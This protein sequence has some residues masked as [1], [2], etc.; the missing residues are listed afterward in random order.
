MPKFNLHPRQRHHLFQ[1]SGDWSMLPFTL[2]IPSQLNGH[3]VLAL[4]VGL[5]GGDSVPAAAL[6]VLLHPHPA[7]ASEQAVSQIDAH[8]LLQLL[9]PGSGLHCHV[10]IATPFLKR[11]LPSPSP[12]CSRRN[13]KRACDIRIVLN[14]HSTAQLQASMVG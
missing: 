10:E 8:H 1:K 11:S 4:H 5:N 3:F 13:L 12:I 2:G 6:Q 14:G 9:R 7:V